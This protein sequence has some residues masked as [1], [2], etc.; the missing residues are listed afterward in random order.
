MSQRHSEVGV[1]ELARRC[2]HILAHPRIDR[3]AHGRAACPCVQGGESGSLR[4][5]SIGQSSSLS[6]EKNFMKAELQQIKSTLNALTSLTPGRGHASGIPNNPL[7]TPPRGLASTSAAPPPLESLLEDIAV[8]LSSIEGMYT[9]MSH[10]IVRVDH[11]ALEAERQVRDLTHISAGT[12]SETARLVNVVG[13]LSSPGPQLGL[14]RAGALGS[15]SSAANVSP[16]PISAAGLRSGLMV[17]YAPSTQAATSSTLQQHASQIHKLI[18]GLDFLEQHIIRQDQVIDGV[19]KQLVSVSDGLAGGLPLAQ[20]L[21]FGGECAAAFSP[22]AQGP[23]PAAHMQAHIP[24]PSRIPM[25]THSPSAL[26][27]THPRRWPTTRRACWS[28]TSWP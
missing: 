2:L 15:G 9:D 24:C 25:L 16:P 3:G 13:G 28:P 4:P 10:R 22:I 11:R 8:R 19:Q 14:P 18:A 6:M 20:L 26:H 21:R 7:S 27:C 1:G 12:I 23:R 17:D 5:A